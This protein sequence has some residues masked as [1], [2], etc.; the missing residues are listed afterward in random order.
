MI[1]IW[2]G[3]QCRNAPMTRKYFFNRHWMA[4]FEVIGMLV[5]V[6]HQFGLISSI[7]KSFSLFNQI[8]S[9]RINVF[10]VHLYIHIE[11]A[12]QHS[13]LQQIGANAWQ[14]SQTPKF[15][16]FHSSIN[17]HD[18]GSCFMDNSI[19]CIF[20]EAPLGLRNHPINP[21]LTWLKS[22][23]RFPLFY[24]CCEWIKDVKRGTTSVK[25]SSTSIE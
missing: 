4:I 13:R 1:A 10:G 6:K 24:H 15:K 23:N 9:F 14:S 21:L 8:R 16:C 17:S 12:I 5:L 20:Q 11:C 25:L 22:L 19:S 3:L 18:Q 2:L 7:D